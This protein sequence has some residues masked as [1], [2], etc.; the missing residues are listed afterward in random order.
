MCA[1]LLL[2][3]ILSG[4][5]SNLFNMIIMLSLLISRMLSYIFLLLSISHF[6][7]FVWQYKPC[8]WS[9]AI[10]LA[11]APMIFTSLSKSILFICYHK[12]FHFINVLWMI[13]WSWLAL[14][15]LATEL[16]LLFSFLVCLGL[17]VS[18]SISHSNFLFR[19]MLGYSVHVCLFAV[20]QLFWDPAVCLCFVL[21]AICYS[22]SG[23]VLFGK[24]TFC[25]S[26]MHS[27]AS[28]TMSFRVTCWMLTISSA[29]LFHSVHLSLPSAASDSEVV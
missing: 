12:G 10:W 22:L 21:E 13:S 6:L 27:L 19:T 2:I 23:Y 15:M 11:T 8:Q 25:A 28:C 3:C 29:Q 9:F 24:T 7:L 16:R 17:Q 26:D 4:M 1:Y 20:W 5:Y 14:S 18:F